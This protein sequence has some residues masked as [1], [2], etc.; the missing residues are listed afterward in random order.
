MVIHGVLFLSAGQRARGLATNARGLDPVTDDAT[1]T[2]YPIYRYY[3]Q[4]AHLL[5]YLIFT[6]GHG[7][8][9][10]K[11]EHEQH[12]HVRR[13]L[14]RSMVPRLACFGIFQDDR[15]TAKAGG[16]RARNFTGPIPRMRRRR[17][18]QGERSLSIPG[19]VKPVKS[20]TPRLPKYIPLDFIILRCL[21][22]ADRTCQSTKDNP[23][24]GT[25]NENLEI[26]YLSREGI[27]TA[28]C[29][30]YR[31]GFPPCG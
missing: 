4:T 7:K 10:K 15:L 23:E 21:S 20:S 8:K 14:S 3:C 16:P 1:R 25:S 26:S 17:T 6:P 2:L 13:T 30:K 19:P 18:T 11:K 28:T 31:L 22:R 24:V 29:D 12:R 5:T 27:L 9:G